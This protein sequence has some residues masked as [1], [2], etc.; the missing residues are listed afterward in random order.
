LV[1]VA[2]SL[3][4]NG[5]NPVYPVQGK[6]TFEGKPMV[7]GGSISFLPLG[8][9]PGKT[10]GAD[11]DENGTYKMTTYRPGDGSMVGEF[12]VVITQVVEK[13][14]EATPDGQKAPKAVSTV[15]PQ[16]RIPTIY[17]DPMNSPLRATVEAK[18][19]NELNFNLERKAQPAGGPGAGARLADPLGRKLAWLKP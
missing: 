14:P 11:V 1:V 19:M 13:E 17:G 12:R 18:G 7:G 3:G 4:C 10:A 6:I 16:D 15:P 2:G 8:N 9:Q 5:D